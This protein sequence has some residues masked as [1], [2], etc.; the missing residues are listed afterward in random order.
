MLRQ[1]LLLAL[2]TW[3][4]IRPSIKLIPRP[5]LHP[6]KLTPGRQKA[7]RTFLAPGQLL[8]PPA[9]G[10]LDPTRMLRQVT[11]TTPTTGPLAHIFQ[12]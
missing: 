8:G 7:R 12:A 2:S 9:G 1:C 6:I 11:L 4:N 3:R 10:Y 5:H